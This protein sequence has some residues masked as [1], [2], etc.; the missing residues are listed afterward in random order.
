MEKE[1]QDFHEDMEWADTAYHPYNDLQL[2]DEIPPDLETRVTAYIA[3]QR[4]I[5]ASGLTT[6]AGIFRIAELNY[7][8][9]LKG[10][11]YYQVLTKNN[12]GE[13]TNALP[14]LP[15]LKFY[16][17]IF[18]SVSKNDMD[19]I[20]AENEF[21][22]GGTDG[23]NIPMTTHDYDPSLHPQIAYRPWDDEPEIGTPLKTALSEV[24]V[25]FEGQYEQLIPPLM[26]IPDLNDTV[27]LDEAITFTIV[28]NNTYE[29][30]F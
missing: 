8:R 4:K 10:Q 25:I 23:E 29:E 27:G 14:L 13:T 9:G 15:Y 2:A 18:S 26:T 21:I 30:E 7:L 5:E 20:T 1:T 6:R 17:E 12:S 3:R 16:S 24:G 11:L 22:I 19:E 28:T